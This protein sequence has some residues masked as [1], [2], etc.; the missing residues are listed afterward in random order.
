MYPKDNS[1]SVKPMKRRQTRRASAPAQA[2]QRREVTMHLPSSAIDKAALLGGGEICRGVEASLNRVVAWAEAMKR[3]CWI[4]QER[5]DAERFP[6]PVR[7]SC[8]VTNPR[9]GS[10]IATFYV[11]GFEFELCRQTAQHYI[12]AVFPGH[13]G[14]LET[15]DPPVTYDPLADPESEVHYD[16]VPLVKEIPSFR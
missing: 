13:S 9:N 6:Y 4:G 14:K 8:I 15:I 12:H 2:G 7:H 11:S 16:S 1:D 5:E 10:T 3:G